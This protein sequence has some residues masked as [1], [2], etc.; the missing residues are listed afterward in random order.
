MKNRFSIIISDIN[1]SKHY[2]VANIVKRIIFKI[3]IGIIALIWFGL[4][5][6]LYLNN[7]INNL[8]SQNEKLKTKT[9]ILKEKNRTFSSS[10]SHKVQELNALTNKIEDFEVFVG[11]KPNSDLSV[12]KRI[13]IAHT[14]TYQKKFILTQ[15]PSGYPIMYKGITG[16]FG[17]RIHPLTQK[18]Q[19]HTGIDLKAKMNTPIK[20]VASGVVN[21]AKVKKNSGYG[22]LLIIDHNYGFKTLFGHLNKI[23]VKKGDIVKKGQTIAYT[24]NSGL[25]TGPHLHYEVRFLQYPLSPQN[26]LTWNYKNFNAI[27]QNEKKVQWQKITTSILNNQPKYKLNRDDFL[28][29]INNF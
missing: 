9:N 3:V 11:I 6:L 15:I 29:K 4:A 22:R 1:G 25:S 26:F 7:N 21:F 2:R 20:A 16:K 28:A 17:K 19:F 18:N 23:V 24:G 5:V 14:T 8:E 12:S 10:I 13:S 27:F